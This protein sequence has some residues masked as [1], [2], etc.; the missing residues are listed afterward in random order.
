MEMKFSFV[1]FEKRKMIV[2]HIERNGLHQKWKKYIEVNLHLDEEPN[3]I[4]GS[5]FPS[6]PFIALL[7]FHFFGSVCLGRG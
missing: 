3:S 1:V 6:S 2:Q 7:H 5:I 4:V